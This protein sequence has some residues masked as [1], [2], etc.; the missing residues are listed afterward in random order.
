MTLH[1][2]PSKEIQNQKRTNKN[3]QFASFMNRPIAFPPHLAT[4]KGIEAY[5]I[6]TTP[7]TFIVPQNLKGQTGS[8]FSCSH[9]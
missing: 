6:H 2:I 1:I 9:P 4:G 5:S 8:H 7:H 3:N